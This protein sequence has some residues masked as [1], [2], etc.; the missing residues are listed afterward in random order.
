MKFRMFIALRMPLVVAI[1]GLLSGLAY[2]QDQEITSH[3]FDSDSVLEINLTANFKSLQRKKHKD[4]E[5]EYW[6]K[7]WYLNASSDTI[8]IKSKIKARGE[9][10]KKLCPFPPLRLDLPKK[11]VAGT[12]FQGENKL[13]LVTH[14]REQYRNQTYVQKEYLIYKIYSV[15]SDFSFKAR[16]LR[17]NYYDSLTNQPICSEYAFALED[18]DDLASRNDALVVE[19]EGLHPKFLRP[20]DYGVMA[21]FQYMIGN[22][23]WH[24]PSLHNLYLVKPRDPNSQYL[25]AVPFDFDYSGIINSHYAVVRDGLPIQSVKERLY[26]G[27]CQNQDIVK[28]VLE[29]FVKHKQAVYAEVAKHGDLSDQARDSMIDYLDDF[30]QL[31]QNRKGE[32]NYKIFRNCREE[33]NYW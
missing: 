9:V 16:M 5:P 18:L 17:I 21:V 20:F 33:S 3:L 11:K 30:Y 24:E 31:I 28:A 26:R 7:L 4:P 22:T 29:H 32:L 8:A 6:A 15:I 23:D 14:C 19:K 25:V 12:W 27:L 2:A 10:R 1:A 13:K